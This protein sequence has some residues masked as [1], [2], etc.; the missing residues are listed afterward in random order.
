VLLLKLPQPAPSDPIGW[1]QVAL[2]TYI[3]PSAVESVA[4]STSPVGVGLGFVVEC[5][6]FRIQHLG[7]VDLGARDGGKC[8]NYT[9][10]WGIWGYT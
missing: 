8:N 1:N 7:G 4:L 2:L 5:H 6:T 10:I 9:Q 3:D